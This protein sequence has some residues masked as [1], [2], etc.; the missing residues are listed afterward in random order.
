MM[1][2]QC[3]VM[4]QHQS[5]RPFLLFSLCTSF[6]SASLPA[7]TL[8]EVLQQNELVEG[9][10]WKESRCLVERAASWMMNICV[11]TSDTIVRTVPLM[12]LLVH[13]FQYGFVLIMV[14]MVMSTLYVVCIMD[15]RCNC[16]NEHGYVL[17]WTLTFNSVY[18]IYSVLYQENKF[19]RTTFKYTIME[20]AI[21]TTISVGIVVWLFLCGLLHSWQYTSFVVTA[22][23][24][25]GMQVKFYSLTKDF[26]ERGRVSVVGRVCTEPSQSGF[27]KDYP[28]GESGSESVELLSEKGDNFAKNVPGNETAQS[29]CDQYDNKEEV[30]QK[31]F[32]GIELSR[33]ILGNI[34]TSEINVEEKAKEFDQNASRYEVSLQ[35]KLADYDKRHNAEEKKMSRGLGTEAV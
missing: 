31:K 23:L 17:G 12:Y 34:S 25:F 29:F 20:S 19:R 24:T 13:S 26:A 21:R 5:F 32:A 6:Q 18:K 16:E 10:Q 28:G 9:V 15:V 2:I 4:V 1:A 14:I 30:V 33:V 3:F 35:S 11:W 7:V 22:F 27:S 8:V